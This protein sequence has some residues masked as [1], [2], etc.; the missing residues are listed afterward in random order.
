[1]AETLKPVLVGDPRDDRFAW[2]KKFLDG[3]YGVDAV[4]VETFDKL[5]KLVKESNEFRKLAGT[6]KWSLIFI[7]DDLPPTHTKIPTPER[8]KTYFT[9]LDSLD[10]LDDF[11][12]VLISGQ[13][14]SIDW[15]GITLP[16]RSIHLCS[17]PPTQEE[18][19]NVV[20]ELHGCGGLEI[21]TSAESVMCLDENNRTLREQIRTLGESRNLKDGKEKLGK[22]IGKCF[23]CRQVNKVT[24]SQLGQ[25]KSG[26]RVFHLRVESDDQKSQE[27]VLKLCKAN[28]RWKLESEV[29]GHLKAKDGLGHS[30][31]KKHIA[32][33]QKPLFAASVMKSKAEEEDK[34]ITQISPWYAV[35]YD[36]LGGDKFGRGIFDKFINLETALVSSA[37]EL[38]KKTAG[39]DLNI[40]STKANRSHAIRVLVLET[41]LQWLCNNWYLNTESGV[42]C[43]EKKILWDIGDAPE[44]EYIPMPP[45]KLTGRSKD[46][47]QS[48][49]NSQE[50]EMGV[51]FFTGWEKLKDKVFRL[52]SE[53]SPAA[54]QLG[55]L[56]EPVPIV[57]S[58]VHGDLNANNI[59]LWLKEGHPFLIDFPFYQEAG[60]ALQDFAQ[61]EV[62]IKFALLDRQRDSPEKRLKAF[63]HTYSQMPIW[64]QMEDR[65]LDQWDQKASRWLST[66][67]AGNVRLC[68]ELVQLVRRKAREVQQN[69]QCPGPSAGD[70]LAE[71]LP[72]LLYH[73]VRAI[74]YP[75]LS[76][77]KR[78]LAVYSAGSI[79]TRLNCF[80]DFD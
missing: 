69:D 31:Y 37:E 40:N 67:Y 13:N 49:L 23:D 41:I 54:A 29:R 74:S 65:L 36:F 59:L 1:M 24:V 35:Y 42:V 79:L 55:K 7:A 48:F 30:G 12:M 11:V 17:I 61:L 46:W 5:H 75:S 27:F 63:E 43:R 51:R 38:S 19:Q 50:A 2:L 58:H 78:L 9:I 53:D 16:D 4:Q 77:F 39:I 34:Y 32:E 64:R 15:R 3:E 22:L 21:V 52:V 68:Y 14:I 62:E 47:I 73:T 80:S 56:G 72:A 28:D 8:V 26:A 60:H 57:L 70:F 18:Y 20:R 66:G 76:V 71:Y 44:R 25:G 10:E 6:N 45:Y 33:L